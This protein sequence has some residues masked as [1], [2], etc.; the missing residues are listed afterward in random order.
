MTLD[1]FNQLIRGPIKAA[2]GVTVENPDTSTVPIDDFDPDLDNDWE[3]RMG[4]QHSGGDY[5]GLWY[6]FTASTTNILHTYRIR[7]S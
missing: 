7:S 2:G 6:E 5:V 3:L 1:D 4:D